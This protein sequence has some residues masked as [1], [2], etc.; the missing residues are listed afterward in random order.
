MQVTTIITVLVAAL[1]VN[2][3]PLEARN[4]NCPANQNAKCC[5]TL[6]PTVLGGALVQVGI[7]CVP[8]ECRSL[9]N[10]SITV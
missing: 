9:S 7:G 6:I 10:N 4:P 8:S 1:A 5:N 3:A 2:G